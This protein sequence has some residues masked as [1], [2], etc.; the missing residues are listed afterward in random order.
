MT[1]QHFIIIFG[2][3]QLLLSQLPNIH[4]LR[5]LNMVSTAA[6]LA[7]A[8]VTT[9]ARMRGLGRA[10]CVCACPRMWFV[11][12]ARA[13]L[14][15]AWAPAPRLAQP[16]PPPDHLLT[17]RRRATHARTPPRDGSRER[18][19]RPGGGPLRRELRSGGRRRADAHHER[20]CCARHDRL[21]VRARACARLSGWLHGSPAACV[22][23]ACGT[24]AHAHACPA[25]LRSQCF[26][27]T[28]S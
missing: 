13:P 26:A 20:V 24:H 28:T 17:A 21:Q 25:G 27:A 10:P 3:L 11:V 2:A 7:F 15:C 4:S 23:R 18:G 22:C 8:V 19:Q 16:C 9:G 12:G 14:V 1:L 6:T 5:L